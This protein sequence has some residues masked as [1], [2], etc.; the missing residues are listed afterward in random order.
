VDNK[1]IRQLI[2]A[3]LEGGLDECR[4]CFA[5]DLVRVKGIRVNRRELTDGCIEVYE[6]RRCGGEF[7]VYVSVWGEDYVK[8]R[9]NKLHPELGGKIKDK[10]FHEIN[11]RV[12]FPDNLGEYMDV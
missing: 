8:K 5:V 4:W 1:Q 2:K 11:Q 9:I 10:L 7:S 12:L 3:H 6:C